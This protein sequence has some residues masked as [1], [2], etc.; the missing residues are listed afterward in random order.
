MEKDDIQTTF[1]ITLPVDISIY[2]KRRACECNVSIE[3]YLIS[4]LINGI[5][6]KELFSKEDR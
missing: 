4:E 5:S 1:T 2:L 3:D 6:A